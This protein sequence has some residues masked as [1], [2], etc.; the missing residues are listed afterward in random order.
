MSRTP[1]FPYV[2]SPS[3]NFHAEEALAETSFPR[4]AI[5]CVHGSLGAG[6]A[7][8]GQEIL[9]M[10]YDVRVVTRNG[11]ALTSEGSQVDHHQDVLDL[12]EAA[13]GGAHLV[14]TSTGALIAAKAAAF[15]P[16]A[17]RSLTLI[18]PPAFAIAADIPPVASAI[19]ALKRHWRRQE[20]SNREFMAGFLA[21]LNMTRPVPQ[22][23]PLE[24]DRAISL[25]R[26]EHLWAIDMP[27]GEL[28]DTDIP[29][30]VVAGGWSPVYDAI[31]HRV[32]SLT[33]A[34]LETIPGFGHAV[35]KAGQAFNHVLEAHLCRA[36]QLPVAK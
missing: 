12:V 2:G 9:D 11:Y 31:C 23:I 32:A 21:A 20:L 14:G 33:G 28:S 16:R 34:R 15:C 27:V 8:A 18:E 7:F 26:S 35:Q 22:A 4:E 29:V 10:A 36:R 13:G 1:S 25:L 19:D 6:D 3:A 30:L 5:I 24:L 17:V